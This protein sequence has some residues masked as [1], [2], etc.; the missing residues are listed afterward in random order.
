MVHPPFQPPKISAEDVLSD[1]NTVN[2]ITARVW[3]PEEP[4]QAGRGMLKSARQPQVIWLALLCAV[5][6]RASVRISLGGDRGQETVAC[7]GVQGGTWRENAEQIRPGEWLLN[8]RAV[9]W[10]WLPGSSLSPGPNWQFASLLKKW[11]FLDYETGEVSFY[12]TVAGSHIYTFPHT[13]FS[14][15]LWPCFRAWPWAHYL[16]HLPSVNR[17]RSWCSWPSA[18]PFSGNPSGPDLSWREWRAS[19][20][21][22]ILASPLPSLQLRVSS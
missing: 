8:Y 15:L 12:N 2:P 16:D 13:S 18:W 5:A 10:E 22:H 14:R 4:A 6:A 19:G 11:G 7:G 1:P 20:W 3:W 17:R 9:W 21:S